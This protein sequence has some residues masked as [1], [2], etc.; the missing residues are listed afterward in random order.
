[1]KTITEWFYFYIFLNKFN[2]LYFVL[3][4]WCKFGVIIRLVSVSKSNKN[5]CRLLTQ[6]FRC[7]FNH[8]Q[9]GYTKFDHWREW[10]ITRNDVQHC[11]V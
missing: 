5:N 10:S 8:I 4:L 7:V 6:P 2:S 11:P 9:T 1:M 3:F